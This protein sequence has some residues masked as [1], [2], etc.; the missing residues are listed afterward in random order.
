MAAASQ[1]AEEG[2]EPPEVDEN[3]IFLQAAEGVQKQLVYSVG[4]SVSTYYTSSLG[5]TGVTSSR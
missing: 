5:T 4:S 3:Q 1:P 2:G